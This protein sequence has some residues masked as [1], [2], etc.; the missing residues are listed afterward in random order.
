[1]SD[2]ITL[3]EALRQQVE[4]HD[5]FQDIVAD[6][7][8]RGV[9]FEIKNNHKG[10]PVIHSRPDARGSVIVQKIAGVVHHVQP[11]HYAGWGREVTFTP[12]PVVVTSAACISSRPWVA[13]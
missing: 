4:Q 12:F 3:I 7:R 1:M 10:E 6:L 13:V 9:I 5:T 11:S 8:R 2:K